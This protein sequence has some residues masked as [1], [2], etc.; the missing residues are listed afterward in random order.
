VFWNTNLVD[1]MP[2]SVLEAGAS[3]LVIVATAVGGIP[4]LVRDGTDGVLVDAG[5]DEA[6]ARTVLEL[7]DDPERAAALSQGGRAM[8]ERSGWPQVHEQWRQELELILPNRR[9]R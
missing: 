9:V 8:A 5:D 4:A 1:N 6:I 2:V 3:G 7:L